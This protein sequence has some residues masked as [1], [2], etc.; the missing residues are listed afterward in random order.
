MK[1]YNEKTKTTLNQNAVEF[2]PKS[3][4][5]DQLDIGTISLPS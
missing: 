4:M 3:K 5:N 2:K 1:S